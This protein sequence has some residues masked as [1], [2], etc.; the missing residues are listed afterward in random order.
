[1]RDLGYV[2][3]DKHPRIIFL[4]AWLSTEYDMRRYREDWGCK[5]IS[6]WPKGK[7]HILTTCL[8]LVET[9]AVRH[10]LGSERMGQL[11]MDKVHDV[12]GS[13]RIT[14]R[15]ENVEWRFRGAVS[16]QG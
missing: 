3:R 12:L 8:Q 16:Q 1:M 10:V 5:N 4:V 15:T 6:A 9:G 11:E 14:K 2:G 13:R 7:T